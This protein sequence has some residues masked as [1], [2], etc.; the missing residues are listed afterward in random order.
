MSRMLQEVRE[1]PG[2]VQVA[3]REDSERYEALGR[4]LRARPPGFVATIARGSSDHA[5]LYAAGLIAIRAGHA[6]ASLQPSWITR[7][8]ARIDLSGALVLAISQSGASPD[9]VEALGAARRAGG[10]T[11]A[12]VNDAE[13]ELAREAEWVLP[14]RAGPEKAVAATKSFIL[15]LVALARLVAAWTEDAALAVAL[16]QLPNRLAAAL[17]CDWSDAV[18]FLDGEQQSGAFV[19]ARGPALAIAHEAALKLKE[20]CYVH[21]EALSSAEILHG[22]F[23]V[24]ADGFPVLGFALEDE[25]GE[26]TRALAEPVTKAGA[27]PMIAASGPVSAGL[28]LPLPAPVHP[29]LDPIVAITAFYPFAEVLARRRGIDPDRPRNLRKVTRTT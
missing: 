24:L 9:L 7:Y 6:T 16:A 21:A 13:S 10:L 5:A 2:L 22:P 27:Q 29:L 18:G 14:Q 26:D 11:V 28:R 17:E 8:G 20:T 1:T 23:A 12:L 3:L 19:V 15:S 4:R 25:G